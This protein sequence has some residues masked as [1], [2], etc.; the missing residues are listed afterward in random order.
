M[1]VNH[2][3]NANTD[4]VGLLGR[5][6]Y[7]GDRNV[8][9]DLRL[10]RTLRLGEKVQAEAMAEVFNIANTLN[11]TDINTV[12]GS[13]SLIGAVPTQFGQPVPSP[14][15]SFGSIRAIDPPRQIQF[16]LRIHF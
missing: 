14:L 7:R 9:F 8:D 16:V 15:A 2:D 3:G 6:T 5:D 11:V 4:R 13:G 1:D 10:A 12:Y